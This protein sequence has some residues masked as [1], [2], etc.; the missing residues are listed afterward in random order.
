M[1]HRPE[2]INEARKVIT[3]ANVFFKIDNAYAMS[4]PEESFDHVVGSSVLHHLEIRKALSEIFRVLKPGGSIA[5]T[6]PN[7]MNPQIAIQKNIPSI[8]KRMGDSPDETAFFKWQIKRLLA[9][10]GFN[11]IE[12]IPFDFLHPAVPPRLIGTIKW[13][14]HVAERIPLIRGIAGSLYITA[15]KS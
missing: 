14:G 15:I 4:F 1:R 10:A 3:S 11:S 7:M 8:K 5:F 9:Q 6:E 13:M 2:L 12:V